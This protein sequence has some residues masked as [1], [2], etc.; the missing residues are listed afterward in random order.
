MNFISVEG[1][2]TDCQ[3]LLY[4]V[5]ERYPSARKYR[6]VFER[7][8][9]SIMGIIAQGKHEPRNPVH[10]DPNVQKGFANFE[11]QWA[12]GMGA[13]FSYMVNAMTGNMTVPQFDIT[14]DSSTTG[15]ISGHPDQSTSNLDQYQ[16][17]WSGMQHPMPH[18]LGDVN[19]L[20]ALYQ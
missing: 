6:D 18:E 2:L 14:M 20:G 12:P 10:I 19:N 9:S 11:G 13:D 8:K 15:L 7:I 3:I 1:P 16:A 17:V 4:I 5:T